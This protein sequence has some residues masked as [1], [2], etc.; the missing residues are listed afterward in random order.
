MANGETINNFFCCRRRCQKFEEVPSKH[1]TFCVV[2]VE[3]DNQLK[4]L[5]VEMWMNR[6]TTLRK[7]KKRTWNLPTCESEESSVSEN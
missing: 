2:K 5:L 6:L 7:E 4:L 1:R 3:S